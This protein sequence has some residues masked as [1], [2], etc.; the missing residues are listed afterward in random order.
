M[1][2]SCGQFVDDRAGGSSRV[3]VAGAVL[4]R[5]GALADLG[6]DL[7]GAESLGDPVGLAETLERR[8]RNDHSVDVG[9]GSRGDATSHVAAQTGEA[10][11]TAECRKLALA[12]L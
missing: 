4:D 7:V 5:D 8:R 9:L 11:I 12:A 10:Q 6:H 3:S 2:A 1:N